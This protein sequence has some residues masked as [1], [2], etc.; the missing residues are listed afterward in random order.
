MEIVSLTE[1][2][3]VEA[4]EWDEH[5]FSC[6]YCI[7][8]EFPEECVEPSGENRGKTLAKKVDWL[9][10]ARKVFGDCGK[11]IYVEGKP[12]GYAQYAP[13]K[14]LP[15]SAE[16][17]AGRPSGDAVLISCLFIAEKEYRRRGLG[18]KL[19]QSVIEDLRRRGV[20]AVETFARRNNPNNPSG[21]VEFYLKNGFM[22]LRGDPE[23]P[24][25]RIEL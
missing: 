15:R 1:E 24:L 14:M 11:L 10:S 2:N 17:P 25:M 19:L 7:Y 21:P 6:K 23:F 22:V 5:P 8:W 4:P 9:R 16:Y 20:K 3:L 18:K 13:P 12:V